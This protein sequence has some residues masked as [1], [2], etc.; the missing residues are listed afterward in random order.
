MLPRIC[1]R[2]FD[3][4]KRFGAIR[5]MMDNRPVDINRHLYDLR[6]GRFSTSAKN[7]QRDDA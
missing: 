5:V 1:A 2:F 3:S 6:W 4:P 7:K